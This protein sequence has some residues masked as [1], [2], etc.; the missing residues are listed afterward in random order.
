MGK[1][2]IAPN[3][4]RIRSF[5]G[6]T[7]S[8][9]AEDA[10]ISISAYRKIEIGKSVPRADTL[11]AI[12]GSLGVN[13][14]KLVAP[15]L[16]L[17]E[18]R[19]RALKKMTA[20]EQILVDVAA[21]LQ[22][23]KELEALLGSEELYKL[24]GVVA[25]LQQNGQLSDDSFEAAIQVAGK[26]REVLNVH[27]GEVIRDICGLLESAGIKV[28]PYDF[29]SDSFFGLSVGIGDGGPAIVVNINRRMPVERW[30]FSAFHE[31]GHLLLHMDAFDVNKRV[32]DD[33]QEKEA[34]LFASYFLMPDNLFKS[35]WK[36][37]YGLGLVRRVLKVKRIFKVSYGTVLHRLIEHGADKSIWAKYHWQFKQ[38][39]GRS[40]GGKVEPLPIEP[41]EF[42]EV[43]SADEAANLLPEDFIPDRLYRL[44]RIAVNKEVI[45]LSRAAEIL[46]LD[47]SEM[48]EL[49]KSWVDCE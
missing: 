47:L 25:D 48:R 8:K 30:I 15:I 16:T 45:S 3:I 36:N 4:R 35:E 28:L 10:R 32:E 27:P 34:N 12:A 46:R 7:Q 21:W 40:L 29:T 14:Q 20:R 19:F 17:S 41:K 38:I 37:A 9:V 24:A 18:V 6:L 26:A 31:L 33:A 42:A 44:V 23:Y 2:V 39:T 11:Q 5:K 43:R 1:E 49:S 13:I 22:N